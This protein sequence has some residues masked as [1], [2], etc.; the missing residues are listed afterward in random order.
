MR[1]L[2]VGRGRD[3]AVI[4]SSFSLERGFDALT[5]QRVVWAPQFARL[6]FQRVEQLL[7]DLKVELRGLRLVTDERR[8]WGTRRPEPLHDPSPGEGVIG[9]GLGPSDCLQAVD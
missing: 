9:Q 5:G 3:E 2:I 6:P 7:V 8:D 4:P 1:S